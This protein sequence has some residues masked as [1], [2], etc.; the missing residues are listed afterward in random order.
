MIDEC[1]R[2]GANDESSWRDILNY[3]HL[4]QLGLTPTPGTDNVDTYALFWR[5]GLHLFA[6]D[7]INDGFLTPFR[8]KQIATTLDD[9]VYTPDDDVEEGEIERARYEEKG[10]S[11]ASSRSR[12][13]SG[14][15]VEIF[16]EQIDQNEK[17]LVFA[18]RNCTR[19]WCATWINQ[20]KTSKRTE[21]RVRVTANDG[22]LGEQHLRDFQDNEKSIPPS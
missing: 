19:W 1:H 22:A 8:V 3:L 2:G 18:R 12:S 6:K 10:F 5:A 11:T 20:T 13:A 4:R 7:G 14:H 21:L 9:Y 15:R 17:T 16:M